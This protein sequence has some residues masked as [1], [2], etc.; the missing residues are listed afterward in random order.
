MAPVNVRPTNTSA[1]TKGWQDLT[2]ILGSI[3]GIQRRP[4]PSRKPS[5]LLI[6]NMGESSKY[7]LFDLLT[8]SKYAPNY[9]LTAMSQQS[10]LLFNLP[11]MIAQGISS[12][13]REGAPRGTAYIGDDRSN[14]VKNSTNDIFR[15]TCKK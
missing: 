11:N 9:T 3:V 12:F 6:E 4:L 8:Y 13:L 2:G 15:K 7:R 5:D 10:S 1:I 14:D